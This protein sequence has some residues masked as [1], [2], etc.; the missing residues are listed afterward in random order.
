MAN[1]PTDRELKRR[2]AELEI[3]IQHLRDHRDSLLESK[4]RYERLVNTIPCAVYDYIRWPDGQSKFVYISS[5]CK[6]IFEHEAQSIIQEPDLLWKMVYK[7]DLERLKKEDEDANISGNMF[8]S[9]VR[10]ILPSGKTKWIQLTSMPSAQRLESQTIWSGV[11]L[12][13]SDR[14]EAENERNRL[15]EELQKTLSEVKTLKGIIPICSY[16]K[17]I[18]DDKGF[19]SQVEA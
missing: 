5:Q 13:I 6:N 17:K 12:D 1:T 2:C 7:D 4:I 11:I 10:I 16:C 19:W 14:K 18:R 8:Q 9:E 3:E 15:L